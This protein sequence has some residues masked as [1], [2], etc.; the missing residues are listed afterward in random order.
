MRND[1]VPSWKSPIG[2]CLRLI[3]VD[4]LKPKRLK[5]QTLKVRKNP[6]KI[7]KEQMAKPRKSARPLFLGK[8]IRQKKSGDRQPLQQVVKRPARRPKSLKKPKKP[9]KEKTMPSQNA[10]RLIS[11][12]GRLTE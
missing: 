1:K 2:S 6:L 11:V 9:K 7:A 12:F 5:K 8:R 3:A 4:D 10:E